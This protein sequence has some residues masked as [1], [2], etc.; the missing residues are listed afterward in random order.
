MEFYPE[1]H[2]LHALQETNTIIPGRVRK[3]FIQ[4]HTAFKAVG[5][6]TSDF[7]TI[8]SESLQSWMVPVSPEG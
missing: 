4:V 6:A 2:F 1:G 3:H 5:I 7:V 8:P